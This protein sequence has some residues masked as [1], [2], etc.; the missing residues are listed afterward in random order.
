MQRV[1]MDSRVNIAF[2]S[3][4][5]SPAFSVEQRSSDAVT[6]GPKFVSPSRVSSTLGGIPLPSCLVGSPSFGN[7]VSSGPSVLPVPM[8]AGIVEGAGTSFFEEEIMLDQQLMK[9]FQTGLRHSM[10]D[11]DHHAMSDL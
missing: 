7:S 10:D 2:P 6:R 9:T 3:R 8:S 11:R 5:L 4:P 1:A